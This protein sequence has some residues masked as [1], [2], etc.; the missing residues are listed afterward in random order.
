[1]S[2]RYEHRIE[3]IKEHREYKGKKYYFGRK[4]SKS[5]KQRQK[6]RKR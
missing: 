2:K 5:A 3:S 1:M 4:K 6:I